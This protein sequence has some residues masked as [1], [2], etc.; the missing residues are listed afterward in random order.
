MAV[1]AFSGGE[2]LQA[3]LEALAKKVHNGGE[4]QVGF[5]GDA[6]GYDNGAS[7]PMV[8]AIQEFGAPSKGIPP[9]PFF[10][11]MIAK[12][13]GSWGK[14]LDG[15]L[16]R[17]NLDASAALDIMGHVMVGQLQA[18]IIDTTSP[19][20]S[21]VTLLL[22]A[23]FGNNPQEITFADVMQARRDVASGKAPDVTETQSKPLVWTGHLLDSVDFEVK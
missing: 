17:T 14:M 11:N 1:K 5:I 22:R 3:H 16:K 19:P 21:K 4:L 8:A 9:R 10:R 6:G 15:A 23:R 12:N 20:L 2:K 18:S 7:V 13:K